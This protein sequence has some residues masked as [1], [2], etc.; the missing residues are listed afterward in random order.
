MCLSVSGIATRL[1]CKQ[2]NQHTMHFHRS[3]S[4]AT[5]DVDHMLSPALRISLGALYHQS[6]SSLELTDRGS[7]RSEHED[8]DC[9]GTDLSQSASQNTEGPAEASPQRPIVL[10]PG[11]YI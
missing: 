7:D 9:R 4:G 2:A 10:L 8:L 11:A 3:G 6:S 5:D 1:M